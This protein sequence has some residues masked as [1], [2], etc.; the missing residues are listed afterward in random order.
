MQVLHVLFGADHTTTTVF[1]NT[2]RYGCS[3]GGHIVYR[4]SKRPWKFILN[5]LYALTGDEK[6]DATRKGR[7][8][9]IALLKPNAFKL[10]ETML[11]FFLSRLSKLDSRMFASLSRWLLRM[12]TINN[13]PLQR[14]C[15]IDSLILQPVHNLIDR[16][17]VLFTERDDMQ[18]WE[19]L[20]VKQC[21]KSLIYLFEKHYHGLNEEQSVIETSVWHK[22]N[23]LLLTDAGQNFADA[24]NITR[25]RIEKRDNYVV[26][27]DVYYLR[28][29][30]A[31]R[32]IDELRHEFSTMAT[33]LIN[34]HLPV[35][36]YDLN[37]EVE[38]DYVTLS[39]ADANVA[40]DVAKQVLLSMQK[41]DDRI[42]FEHFVKFLMGK[43]ETTKTSHDMQWAF[44]HRY[45]AFGNPLMWIAK[46]LHIKSGVL[47]QSFETLLTLEYNSPQSWEKHNLDPRVRVTEDRI[48]LRSAIVKLRKQPF[49]QL[50]FFKFL[51]QHVDLCIGITI[52][53]KVP[54][55]Y[56]MMRIAQDKP[57]MLNRRPSPTPLRFNDFDLP[58]V[59]LHLMQLASSEPIVVV[60]HIVSTYDNP[61]DTQQRLVA[62]ICHG[63]VIYPTKL[64]GYTVIDRIGAGDVL[65]LLCELERD[66]IGT[67]RT[68]AK[69]K[70]QNKNCCTLCLSTVKHL[71]DADG[72]CK[73]CGVTFGLIDGYMTHPLKQQQQSKLPQITVR[74]NSEGVAKKK[75]SKQLVIAE[76]LRPR[77]EKHP[78][79]EKQVLPDDDSQFL[80]E[81][82]IQHQPARPLG[83]YLFEVKFV[84]HSD[85]FNLW[86]HQDDLMET[87]PDGVN[88]YMEENGLT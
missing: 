1:M 82:I 27:A 66:A 88:A 35:S 84:D 75:R 6:T 19:N 41:L 72:I 4:P 65:A 2:I 67:I 20:A 87:M 52:P 51:K 73:Q 42:T 80:I 68:I 46:L 37:S 69:L 8:V 5:L 85:E 12:I 47:S 62:I 38:C 63:G 32:E 22:L 45:C 78:R 16:A 30:Q 29:Q 44:F 76:R 21:E 23:A 86:Y 3:S 50:R 18:Q 39:G 9:A 26:G 64:L 77:K 70:M 17:Q 13:A 7:S 43:R 31:L 24:I 58:S 49:L 48:S 83:T 55:V 53:Q 34:N 74:R 57:L 40:L 56:R 71:D 10:E 36:Y 54:N 61:L 14:G 11:H 25:S 28:L 33:F 81:R 15:F 79:K 59:K 60:H